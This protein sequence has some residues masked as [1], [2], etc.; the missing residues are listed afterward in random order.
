MNS[1]F[2]NWSAIY[3]TPIELT[4]AGPGSSPDNTEIIT[5]DLELPSDFSGSN[6]SLRR[7]YV[8]T[9]AIAAGVQSGVYRVDGTVVYRIKPPTTV[10]TSGRISTIAY[11]GT[12]AEGVL[13]AG[14][15]KLL[16]RRGW[17]ISGELQTLP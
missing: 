10:P 2:T 15:V 6:P 13:L 11:L 12:Y 14:E 7:F 17:C 8:S 3:V 1:N 16:Q 4:T 5:A 9:D